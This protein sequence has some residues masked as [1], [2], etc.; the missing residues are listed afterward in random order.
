MKRTAVVLSGS[1]LLAALALTGPAARGDKLVLRDGTVR[2]GKVITRTAGVVFFKDRRTGRIEQ[3][4]ESK[5]A[6]VVEE[7]EAPPRTRPAAPSPT[8]P[9]RPSA[10]A[11]PPAKGEP[12]AARLDA[13][14]ALSC[15]E[16][17]A[18]A[19]WAAG[20]GAGVPEAPRDP[21]TEPAWNSLTPY[22]QK[23]KLETYR[24]ALR[25][26]EQAVA[27]LGSSRL[28]REISDK[29]RG[30]SVSW[31]LELDS[32]EKA[33]DG[34]LLLTAA[35]RRG[36]VVTAALPPA[37]REALSKVRK[38]QP[39]LLTGR[40][41][42]WSFRHEQRGGVF[43]FQP[44]RQ[45]TVELAGAA[46]GAPDEAARRRFY[47]PDGTEDG[48][49]FLVERA[50]SMAKPL[51]AVRGPLAEGVE[52]LPGGTMF[53]VIFWSSRAA[54]GPKPSLVAATE[55]QK[56]A[57]TAFIQK[58]PAAGER[59]LLPSLQRAFGLLRSAR[60]GRR[61]VFL[62]V[63]G[64]FGG[65]AA[66]ETH[67]IL[68]GQVLTGNDAVLQWLRDNNPRKDVHV[69][70]VLVHSREPAAIQV[71]QAIARENAGECRRVADE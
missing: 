9:A 60:L 31:V 7:T 67:R 29:F 57:A 19:L 16:A 54:S 35:S 45:F 59:T 36:H 61:T 44:P 48:V 63:G 10:P 42:A 12:D 18:E 56:A 4:P 40:I 66:G 38:P 43:S 11:K 55:D 1:C 28:S 49:V 68:G 65:E 26:H 62:V 70:A 22:G 17:L 50:A 24:A 52:S 47:T 58:T 41:E 39:I 21:R 14:D 15:P 30:K 64:D 71:M 37:A 5:V 20:K 53:C 34:G 33:P 69:Q 32:L 6:R 13:N 3:V 23:S 25:K 27:R 46:A 8:R 2:E 51:D